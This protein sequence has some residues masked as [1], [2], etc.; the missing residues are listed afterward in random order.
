MLLSAPNIWTMRWFSSSRPFLASPLLLLLRC[1]ISSR[2][3]PIL[4]LKVISENQARRWCRY[5]VCNPAFLAMVQSWTTLFF[6]SLKVSR[7]YLKVPYCMT[8]DLQFERKLCI[9]PSVCSLQQLFMHMRY[10]WF[11][12]GLLCLR[13]IKFLKSAVSKSTLR[14]KFTY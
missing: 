3:Q 8:S 10:Q 2:S 14:S 5:N 12:L 9:L 11:S 4:H 6:T 1:I 7:S 13:D